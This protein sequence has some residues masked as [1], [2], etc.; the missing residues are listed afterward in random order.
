MLIKTALQKVWDFFHNKCLWNRLDFKVLYSIFYKKRW[1]KQ[2][3]GLRI[4]QRDV[5]LDMCDETVF[6][7]TKSLGFPWLFIIVTEFCTFSCIRFIK[8]SLKSMESL[9]NGLQPLSR[10]TMFL[11]IS[12]RTM[13]QVPSPGWL[14]VDA[15]AWCKWTQ[16]WRPSEICCSR[17]L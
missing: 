17:Y 16:S 7:T 14:W 12:M 8:L 10:V 5:L 9:Q 11:L 2:F 1:F 3:F 13:W 15:D 6:S 4:N